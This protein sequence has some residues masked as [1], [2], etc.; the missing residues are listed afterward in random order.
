MR[1]SVLPLV[2][3]SLLVVLQGCT[4][5]TATVRTR[6]AGAGG[7]AG[8]D[9]GELTQDGGDG[10]GGA[11]GGFED[12]GSADAGCRSA[13]DCGGLGCFSGLCCASAAKACGSVCCSGDALCLFDRCQNPGTNC[14]GAGD[15]AAG[16]YC[17]T[18]FGG[19]VD[20]GASAS[21]A[22]RCTV[23]LPPAG[24]C[25][26]LPPVCA[27]DGG[28]DG[29]CLASCEYRPPVGRLDAVVKW[30]WEGR[31]FPAF[32][33]VW[34]TPTVARVF[35]SN[36]D[37]RVDD[38]DPPN[39]IFVSGDTRQTCCQCTG[40]MPSACKTGVLRMLDG[41]TGQELWS[42]DKL[43]GSVGFAALS[44]AI[45]DL[46]RDGRLDIVAATGEG[47]VAII[48]GDGTL[49]RLSTELL[50]GNGNNAFG[51]GGGFSLADIDGDGAPE[52]A[53]GNTV[54]STADGG[55]SLRFQGVGATGGGATRALS[56]FVDLDGRDGGDLELLAGKTAYLTDGGVFW[57]NTAVTDGFPGVGDFDR[58]GRPEVV[59]VEGGKVWLL[60]ATTGMP[61][62]P[63]LTLS[64]TGSG[65]PPTVADFDGDGRPEIGVA[66]QDFYFSVKPN[67]TTMTLQIAWATPNHDF[68]SSVTGS[69]VFDF[70][71]DSRAEVVYGDECFLWVYDG[72]TGAVKFAA[73]TTSFTGTET[74]VVADV[75]GDGHA[76]IV[77]VSNGVDPGPTGWK[78]DM[79]PWNQPDTDAGRPAWRAPADGGLA[80]RGITV[81]GDRANAWVGTRTLWNQHTYHVTNVCDARDSACFPPATYGS[82]PR[83]ERANWG[84]PW[85]NNFR[86]NVL[87][88][89]LFNAPDVTVSLSMECAPLL[90][91]VTVR[92]QGLAALPA[93]VQVALFARRGAMDVEVGR[94]VTT[95]ALNAGQAETL[96]VSVQ[97]GTAQ[98]AFVA[99]VLVDPLRPLFRECRDDNN[100]SA[101]D[102]PVCID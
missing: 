15:C 64:G 41:N 67:F 19:S 70:E 84:V 18:Q 22:G 74:S 55:L 1:A 88:Q 98:D 78:C 76:E 11:G 21:D 31:E 66:Q 9:G 46:D 27:A 14:R 93:G 57:N 65:G 73:L 50:P 30:H 17:E 92:N 99:K 40:V 72:R 10:G 37:G 81:F 3:V 33:D 54:F 94:A 25:V 80:Y 20:A 23:S 58:D 2:V 53:Y 87:D 71:G 36:C 26:P 34:S 38:L 5:G 43:P 16:E 59:L 44:I 32:S 95:R 100:V 86:Q 6:D 39:V 77:M 62:M 49:K 89:G 29:G 51:W 28:S 69:T 13:S 48:N 97:G 102:R 68:S 35:D 56:T 96:A 42:L 91:R 45:G 61:L 83:R 12:G 24:R 79:A 85:L 82:I 75:D 63:A 52:I 4:C 8:Q 7:G 60:S 90:A 101:V 47:R